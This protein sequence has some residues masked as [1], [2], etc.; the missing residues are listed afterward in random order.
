[1]FEMSA[2]GVPSGLKFEFVDINNLKGKETASYS[3]LKF[4]S[5]D[6]A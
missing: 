3:D 1:M 4:L 2:D 6:M 5:L